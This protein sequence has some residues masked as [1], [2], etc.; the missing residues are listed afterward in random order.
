V[1]DAEQGICKNIH[2]F[3]LFELTDKL[4]EVAFS[5]TSM[6]DFGRY[7]FD[8]INRNVAGSTDHLIKT[9]IRAVA[10]KDTENA[11]DPYLRLCHSVLRFVEVPRKVYFEYLR[12]YATVFGREYLE[13][14]TEANSRIG[15][16]NASIDANKDSMESII[17][18]SNSSLHITK[19]LRE[20]EKRLSALYQQCNEMRTQKEMLQYSLEYLDECM[21]KFCDFKD[22]AAV[23][24]ALRR[25]ALETAK[26]SHSTVVDEFEYYQEILR[27]NKANNRDIFGIIYTVKLQ[28]FY[29]DIRQRAHGV[30]HPNEAKQERAIQTFREECDALPKIEVLKEARSKDILEY[31]ALLEDWIRRY[32][33]P[34]KVAEKINDSI[35]ISGR[36]A[37]L[38]KAINLFGSGEYD[39]FNNIAP[40]QLEGLFADLLK[41][42]TVFP[43]FSD[44]NIYPQAV[45]RE[46]ISYIKNL[47]VDVYPEAVMYFGYYF[48]NLVRNKVAHGIY[49][50]SN[51]D[52]AAVFAMEMLLDLNAL[53]HMILR[54][55]ETEKMYRLI[56]GY[57]DYMAAFF[58]K[59]NHHFGFLFNDLTRNR[60]HLDYDSVERLRPMQFAYWLMNPYYEEIYARV[61]D[62]VVL[63]ELRADLTS[64]DFWLFVLDKISDVITTGYDYLGIDREFFSVVK[65]LF[66]CNLPDDTKATLAKV[67]AALTQIEKLR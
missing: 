25:K 38:L 60:T 54:K 24:S 3:I 47:G 30:L 37:I 61:G 13:V 39:V 57:K 44:L 29:D 36:K 12:R 15:T 21:A 1:T 6:T 2:H 67:N 34:G 19:D 4:D 28:P 16:L 59:P 51:D 33:L 52:L 40:I 41:D 17:A 58:K 5:Q 22:R 62:A 32:D 14:V 65:G 45:L 50:Y 63:K 9:V 53:M 18:T 49:A 20:S 64:N 66:R 8:V 35:S 27:I 46:K 23:L 31:R 55:S 26:E 43:R 56:R 42:G 48:N 10:R 11:D 7:L